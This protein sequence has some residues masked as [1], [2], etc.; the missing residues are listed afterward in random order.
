MTLAKQR[1]TLQI[2]KFMDD[3]AKAFARNMLRLRIFESDAQAYEDLFIR[4]MDYAAPDFRPVKPHGNIGDRKNDGFDWTTGTYYQVYAPEDIRR[5]PGDALKKLRE[6]F[7]GLKTFWDGLYPVRRFFYVVNDKYNGVAPDLEAEL[8]KMRARYELDEAKPFLAKDLES[9][10]F[11][12]DSDQIIMIVGHVPAIDAGEFLFLS[13]FTY[14]VGAWVEFERVCRRRVEHPAPHRR[15]I[16]GSALIEGLCRLGLI[17]QAEVQPLLELSRARNH[18]IH[19]DTTEL[20]HKDQIDRL[21]QLTDRIRLSSK[22]T[23]P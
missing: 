5:T 16:V 1:A 3:N 4:V 7:S 23:A 6:D 13:G 15:P 17:P 11:S 10:V 19:G 12:L 9:T 22:H 20:P 21:V 14:F 18:L 2:P 8:A